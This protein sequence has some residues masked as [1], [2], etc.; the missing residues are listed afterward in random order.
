MKAID[1]HSL[2]PDD[3]VQLINMNDYMSEG[4]DPEMSE[5]M[6]KESFIEQELAYAPGEE[7][8][9][10]LDVVE[11]WKGWLLSDGDNLHVLIHIK[12][13]KAFMVR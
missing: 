3:L 6:T 1:F 7:E 11:A 8:D 5:P 10:P 13:G 4:K 2:D 12:E 9:E